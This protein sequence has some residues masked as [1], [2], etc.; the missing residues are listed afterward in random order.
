MPMYY[1]SLKSVYIKF[2]CFSRRTFSFVSSS[3]KILMKFYFNNYRMNE[4]SIF[5]SEHTKKLVFKIE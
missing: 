3:L 5:D 4:Q 1:L 2:G